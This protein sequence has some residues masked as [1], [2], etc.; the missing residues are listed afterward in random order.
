MRFP[1][2]RF[3]NAVVVVAALALVATPLW[4]QQS[5]V[6]SGEITEAATLRPMAN[7]QLSIASS[8]IGALSNAQ[9][10]Y[11]LANVP[12]GTHEV[13]VQL[14]GFGVSTETVTVEP[15]QTVTLDFQLRRRALELQGIVATGLGESTE[16]RRI[17]N[18]VETIN[19][20]DLQDSPIVNTSEMLQTRTPGVVVAAAEGVAG[21]GSRIRIR[22]SA[23]LTQN[24]RPVVYVDGV[25]VDAST[26]GQ[27][28]SG[29]GAEASRLD[30]LNPES[31]DRIEILK[32]AAAATLYGTEAS[33]GVIQIFTKR[34]TSGAPRW[35]LSME[36]GLSY[37][38]SIPDLAGFALADD[39]TPGRDRGARALSEHW[40]KTIRPYEIFTFD[41]HD[42]VFETGKHFNNSLSV[43][44][45]TELLSYYIGGRY[46]WED[47]IIGGKEYQRPGEAFYS[48]VHELK[49][50]NANF[51]LTPSENLR[52]EMNT[53]FTDRVQNPGFGSFGAAGVTPLSKIEQ[54]HAGN[55]IGKT[56]FNTFRETLQQE[57]VEETKRFGG[58]GTARYALTP[59]LNFDVTTGFD[60][61]SAV[62]TQYRPFGWNV[63]GY[64]NT[65]PRGG[66]N[67]WNRHHDEF[68]LQASGHWRTDIGSQFTSSITVG[69]QTLIANTRLVAGMGE[70]FPARGLEVAG[71]GV[72]QRASENILRTVNSGVYGQQMI[73]FR[74]GLF[75]TY[76]ARV[77]R[78]SAFGEDAD[79]AL[80]PKVSF[81]W[82][83][84]EMMGWSTPTLSTLRL[85]GSLG[86]SGLQP[87]AFDQF[88][89][90][91]PV[92]TVEGGGV[93]P[94]NLGNPDIRPEVSTEWEAGFEAGLFQD[95]VAFEATYWNRTVTDLLVDR[96]FPPSGGFLQRQLIN[97]GEMKA[98]GVELGISGT[99]YS[100][101][102]FSVD[103]FANG[104]F[105]SEKI[106][107]MGGAPPLGGGTRSIHW[108]REGYSPGAMFGAKTPDGVDYPFDINGDGTPDSI[109]DL[110]RFFSVP[111]TVEEVERRTLGVMTD[112]GPEGHYKG[113][114]TPDWTGAFGA[115]MSFRNFTLRNNFQ[116]SVGSYHMHAL[117]YEFRLG[118]PSIGRN[119]V[120]S[121]TMDLQLMNP[122]STP[123]Q[124]LEA[125]RWFSENTMSLGNLNGMNSAQRADFI[126][127][128][129]MSLT[130]QVPGQIATR[131][132]V[133][134]LSITAAG[135]NLMRFNLRGYPGQD[136]ESASTQNDLAE[137][138]DGHHYAAP[139]RFSLALRATF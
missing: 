23:S 35:S 26:G 57:A 50:L 2:R 60:V 82:V 123:E 95:G 97:V 71:A 106:T 91:A 17:G 134:G 75:V 8:G 84:S 76:G 77:D 89:T 56:A 122:Q 112:L 10:R 127:W 79:A 93:S 45:G 4:G 121:A 103:L 3:P 110:L 133:D 19:V 86:Q 39:P 136:Q 102:R 116:Y 54:G 63:D 73:G 108:I 100:S 114:T 74:D 9:G 99:A 14:L 33:N 30:D 48:D 125:A 119:M 41:L 88:T 139:T 94:Q 5:G 113:K 68:T 43:S 25:R 87:G 81:S 138:N 85:R 101:P 21:A 137:G 37:H 129:E 83:A 96:Q 72:I 53:R 59:D 32:G 70:D 29:G 55:K 66:R 117:H 24:N 20:A 11:T 47:G 98:W 31:I 90:F 46:S 69:S 104:A 111:R 18:L 40:G 44:G 109:E 107:D 118:H 7:A 15:G 80:Y 78:H 67:V 49:Q 52:L 36:G 42:Y 28:L 128:R 105:I 135:R 13:Q 12:P 38:P 64:S 27:G 126:R 65:Q 92:A 1:V 132:G 34:G 22:G 62:S 61:V 51:Q 6:I 120:E 16:R 58:S 115:D 130:Y 131:M 124:R